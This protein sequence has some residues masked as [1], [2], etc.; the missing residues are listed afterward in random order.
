[1]SA[2]R[3]VAITEPLVDVVDNAQVVTNNYC[4]KEVS[5]TVGDG[6]SWPL[7]KKTIADRFV[8]G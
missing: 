2:I 6:F 4:L 1:M 5:E 8:H 7:F 3:K